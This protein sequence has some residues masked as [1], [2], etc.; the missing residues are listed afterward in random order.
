MLD[1]FEILTTS[2]VV[3]WSRT[4]TSIAAHAVNGLINDV[5]IEEKVR[6]VL[7]NSTN[8]TYKHEKYTLKYTL[9]KDLGL[10]F[11]AVYQSLLHLTWVDKLLDDVRTIFVEVYRGQLEE[12]DYAALRYPFDKYY[13][14]ELRR[15]DQSTGGAVSAQ[16]PQVQVQEEEKK[17]AE[18][19]D[20]GGPPRQNCLSFSRRSLELCPP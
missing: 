5:F 3:L 18:G 11:V 14:E 16:T 10:I 2:G 1:A 15:L 19:A 6:P 7:T 12:L 4:T 9:V 13:D 17:S 8:P 20:T